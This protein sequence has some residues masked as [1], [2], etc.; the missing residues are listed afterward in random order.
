MTRAERAAYMRKRR[1]G[2]VSTK[3]CVRC[4][5][6]SVLGNAKFCGECAAT[7]DRIIVRAVDSD[8]NNSELAEM[9]DMNITTLEQRKS[10]ALKRLRAAQ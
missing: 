4:V 1:G 7:V 9:L 3:D 2:N 6:G 10:R 8:L 5:T